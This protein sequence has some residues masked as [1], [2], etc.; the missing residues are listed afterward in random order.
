MTILGCNGI[1]NDGASNTDL[2]LNDLA[3]MGWQT[4]DVNY[5]RKVR[6]WQA[7]SRKRQRENAR[8]L[9]DLH[10]PGDAVLA[11]SYGALVVLRAM[12]LGAKFGQVF[13]FGAAMNDDFTFPFN[14]MKRLWNIHNPA[15]KALSMGALL[16]W[17]DFGRM[18]QTGY[19]GPPDPRIHN[20]LAR[21]TAHEIME[22][23]NYFLGGNR[24]KWVK[25]IDKNLRTQ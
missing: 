11:H 18:G 7:R 6:T 3:S 10:Q 19:N 1:R 15:D 13:L 2:I 24:P 8:I 14:G 9:L 22:H 25:F 20:V 4:R 12:E 21:P 17:H 5:K 16:V 23:S